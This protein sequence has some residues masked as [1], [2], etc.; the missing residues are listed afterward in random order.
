MGLKLTP[1]KCYHF[2]WHCFSA[3][4]IKGSLN[5][6]KHKDCRMLRETPHSAMSLKFQHIVFYDRMHT[7]GTPA[8]QNHAPPQHH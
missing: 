8:V 3:L 2:V 4:P 7:G 6:T 5:K 1:A